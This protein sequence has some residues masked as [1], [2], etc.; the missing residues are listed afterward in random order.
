MQARPS[1]DPE[2]QPVRDTPPEG[3]AP[4]QEEGQDTSAAKPEDAAM[5]VTVEA[6]DTAAQE[7][8]GLLNM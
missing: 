8:M 2:T 7:L 6:I 1:D 4:T 5:P 3:Q